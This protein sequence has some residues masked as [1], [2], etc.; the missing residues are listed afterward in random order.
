MGLVIQTL[1]PL[2]IL[3]QL[4]KQRSKFMAVMVVVEAETTSISRQ[5]PLEFNCP[6]H[7]L[8]PD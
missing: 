5:D 7:V 1:T 8:A 3:I 6:I 2:H 4:G